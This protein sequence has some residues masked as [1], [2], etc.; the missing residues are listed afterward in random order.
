MVASQR[1]YLRLAVAVISSCTALVVS[2]NPRSAPP[3]NLRQ[4][5]LVVQGWTSADRDFF[6]YKSQGSELVPYYWFL[7]LEKSGGTDL[8]S[9]GLDRFGYL[10]GPPSTA[11]PN[12]LPIG[13]AKD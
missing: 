9:K 10:Y 12:K 3:K 5:D 2:A 6:Y 13:F 8:F 7:A 11:N 1:I 4:S